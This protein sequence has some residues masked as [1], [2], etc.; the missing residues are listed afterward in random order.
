MSLKDE[1]IAKYRRLI[2]AADICLELRY[3]SVAALRAA[4]RRGRLPFRP[5]ILAGRPGIFAQTQE[6][7]DILE[8][9]I[10]GVEEFPGGRASQELE[11]ASP[12]K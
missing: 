4:K 10:A 12:T 11:E 5:I 6:I 8:N 7:A 2:G 1:L 3:P 9:G